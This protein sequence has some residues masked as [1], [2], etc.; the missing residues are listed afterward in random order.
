M[1][2]THSYWG[3]LCDRSWCCLDQLR[4]RLALIGPTCRLDSLLVRLLICL[5]INLTYILLLR[6]LRNIRLLSLMH[7]LL[8][9]VLKLRSWTSTVDPWLELLMLAV[10]ILLLLL[11]VSILRSQWPL[12]VMSRGTLVPS[13]HW[14]ILLLVRSLVLLIELMI[15]ISRL[16]K[17]LA[18]LGIVSSRTMRVLLLL[19]MGLR[20][21]M[22]SF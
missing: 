18:C 3:T 13:R 4:S 12:K 8:L 6:V 1:R 20:N 10:P 14:L 9:F 19:L 16:L 22:R 11:V 2:R 7:M 21:T 17:I 15:L 5:L